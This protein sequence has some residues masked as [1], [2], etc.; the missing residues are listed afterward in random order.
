MRAYLIIGHREQKIML[1][2]PVIHDI[3]ILCDPIIIGRIF[4]NNIIAFYF[5]IIFSHILVKVISV[6]PRIKSTLGYNPYIPVLL[7]KRLRQRAYY[8]KKNKAKEIKNIF[9]PPKNY[10]F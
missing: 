5:R 4:I 7:A 1:K 6:V 2:A 10:F 8:I 3:A 9:R